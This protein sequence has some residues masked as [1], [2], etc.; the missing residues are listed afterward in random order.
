MVD[1]RTGSV[2]KLERHQDVFVVRAAP[3]Q[4][5]GWAAPALNA[6]P[7]GWAHLEPFDPDL[8]EDPPEGEGEDIFDE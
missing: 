7:E 5:S 6:M 4:P 3:Q 8:E 2:F 1:K